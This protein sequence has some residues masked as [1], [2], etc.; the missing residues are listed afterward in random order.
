MPVEQRPYRLA[1]DLFLRRRIERQESLDELVRARARLLERQRAA[2][3]TREERPVPEP[4]LDV[5]IRGSNTGADENSGPE[6]IDLVS[7]SSQKSIPSTIV[8]SSSR[9]SGSSPQLSQSLSQ[10]LQL[11]GRRSLG[12]QTTPRESPTPQQQRA[13]NQAQLQELQMRITILERQLEYVRNLPP[14]T[15]PPEDILLAD[16]PRENLS[17]VS[18]AG[19]NF[20]YS[21]QGQPVEITGYIGRGRHIKYVVTWS[22]GT[23][24]INSRRNVEICRLGSVLLEEFRR[25]S[26]AQNTRNYRARTSMSGDILQRHRRLSR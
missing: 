24:T 2:G 21:F 23:R 15:D 1:R 26:R 22:D 17:T 19:T 9:S 4:S 12:L 11:P 18:N 6:L 3:D 7:E 14:R 8:I 16:V 13:A 10:S 20:E 25:K 5:A